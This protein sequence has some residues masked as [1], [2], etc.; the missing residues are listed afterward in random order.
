MAEDVGPDGALWQYAARRE[1]ALLIYL[2]RGVGSWA[3]A[4]D[5]Y[6]R[7]LERLW[8]QAPES[9][10]EPAEVVFGLAKRLVLGWRKR[11]GEDDGAVEPAIERPAAWLVEAP[12]PSPHQVLAARE[13]LARV[14]HALRGLPRCERHLLCGARA[15]VPLAALARRRRMTRG[16]VRRRLV[17]ARARLAGL[18]DAETLAQVTALVGPLDAAPPTP[19]ESWM[20]VRRQTPSGGRPADGRSAASRHGAPGPATA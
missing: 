17:E 10:A 19:R 2:H 18:L 12:A 9:E 8:R 3:D 6:G 1:R 14:D 7:L 11:H 16:Q 5:L 20:V 15:G 4:Q 13:L